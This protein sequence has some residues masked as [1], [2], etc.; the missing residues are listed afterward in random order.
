M[1]EASPSLSRSIRPALSS[2]GITRVV[3][4]ELLEGAA[5]LRQARGLPQNWT[6]DQ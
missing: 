3:F 5:F 4:L 1:V 6:S 2:Y